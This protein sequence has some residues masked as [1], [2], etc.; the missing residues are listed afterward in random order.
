M[1]RSVSPGARIPSPIEWVL[2]PTCVLEMII[3]MS[4]VYLY[5]GHVAWLCVFGFSLNSF[6]LTIIQMKHEYICEFFYFFYF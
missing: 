3:G 2:L 1:M 5:S 4:P 6:D